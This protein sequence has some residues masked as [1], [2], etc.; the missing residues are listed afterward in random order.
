MSMP[1]ADVV[2]WRVSLGIIGFLVAMLTPAFA[3]NFPWP[4]MCT[5]LPGIGFVA[6]GVI[7][8]LRDRWA[9]LDGRDQR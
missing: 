2:F 3:P 1:S 4:S 7:G 8:R 9:R 6:G 5:I